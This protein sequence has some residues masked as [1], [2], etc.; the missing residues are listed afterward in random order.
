MDLVALPEPKL[1]SADDLFAMP[2]DARYELI[3]GELVAMP[4]PPGGEHGNLTVSLSAYVTVFADEHDL[5]YCFAAETGFKIASNPD[6]VLAAD[7]AFVAK[8]RLPGGVPVKHVPL[9][10]DII[11]ETRLPGDT[12]RHA[13]SKVLLWLRA[14]TRVVWLLDPKARSLTVNRADSLAQTLSRNDTL[15]VEDIL[16]GFKFHMSRLFR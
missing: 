1:Y 12:Q 13:A 16:P 15:T 14:G 8:D 9:A 2:S 7:F 6:T 11:L 10:P 5:G 3:F 4:P